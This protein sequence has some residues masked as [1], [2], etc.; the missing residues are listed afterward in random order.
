VLI[1]PAVEL[2]FECLLTV[3]C[4]V[5]R[6]VLDHFYTRFECIAFENG[7]DYLRASHVDDSNPIVLKNF[8]HSIGIERDAAP[9]LREDRRHL[10]AEFFQ[11][12]ERRLHLPECFEG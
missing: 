3:V 1:E 8:P 10:L 6:V 5:F 2:R 4:D 7:G 12:F 9:V 11:F